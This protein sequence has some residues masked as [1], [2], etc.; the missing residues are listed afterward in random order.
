LAAMEHVWDKHHFC[1]LARSAPQIF[2]YLKAH[3]VLRELRLQFEYGLVDRASDRGLA[4]FSR[5]DACGSPFA[6]VWVSAVAA[7]DGGW[8]VTHAVGDGH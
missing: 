1:E 5:G 8:V 4:K 6:A 2:A 3:P 7:L